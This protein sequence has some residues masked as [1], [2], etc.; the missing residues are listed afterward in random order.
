MTEA[1][2]AGVTVVAS[3]DGDT[4]LAER[5]CDAI[6]VRA[7]YHDLKARDGFNRSLH[8]ALR[9]DG[10]LVIIDFD[11]GTPEHQSGHGIARTRV[12]DELTSAGFQ[13]L[14][15][16]EDWSGNAYCVV[17]TSGPTDSSRQSS[18]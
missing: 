7:A 15:V 5:C 13:L 12:V 17:F 10:R 14:D 2:E 6:L 18:R 1:A 3:S 16:I 4:G 8:R 11:Q 9:Q